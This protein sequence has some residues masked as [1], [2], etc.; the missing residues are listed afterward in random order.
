M[1]VPIGLVVGSNVGGETIVELVGAPIGLV[2][3]SNVGGGI[4][5]ELVGGGMGVVNTPELEFGDDIAVPPLLDLQFPVPQYTPN[6]AAATNVAITRALIIQNVGRQCCGCGC[7]SIEIGSAS[8]TIWD[9]TAKAWTVGTLLLLLL[10]LI[11][12]DS[13]KG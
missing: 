9:S 11:D 10:L 4:I 6:D 3:G 5:V 12:G 7:R 1:A 8:T 2:V 13:S